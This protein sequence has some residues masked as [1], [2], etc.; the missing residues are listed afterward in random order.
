[1]RKA[2]QDAYHSEIIEMAWQDDVPFDAI[3]RAHGLSE[4]EVIVLMRRSLKPSSF[5]KWRK[6]VSNRPS[7]HA[8]ITAM[9]SS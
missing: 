7:K 6:R 9:S 5:R 1:M 8:V 4:K 3:K 2:D